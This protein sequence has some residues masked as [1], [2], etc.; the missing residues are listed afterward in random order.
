M[1][2]GLRSAPIGLDGKRTQVYDK[3]QALTKEIQ[4]YASV[5]M[6]SKIISVRHTGVVIPKGTSQLMTL[7]KEIKVFDADEALVSCLENGEY[8]YFV[9]VNKNIQKTMNMVILAEDQVEKIG[10]DGKAILTKNLPKNMV[11][12]PGDV[13]IFRYPNKK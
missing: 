13:A 5:F 4:A 7:P 6:G 3:I 11:I 12:E 1:S 9:V 10:K 2:E 8:S